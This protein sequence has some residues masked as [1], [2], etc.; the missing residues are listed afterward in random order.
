VDLPSRLARKSSKLSQKTTRMR[1]TITAAVTPTVGAR[2]AAAIPLSIG[3]RS[4]SNNPWSWPLITIP[5][6]TWMK[7]MMK[8]QIRAPACTR[9][10]SRTSE[11]VSTKTILHIRAL[12]IRAKAGVVGPLA[13]LVGAAF[14]REPVR[15]NERTGELIHSWTM[16]VRSLTK[17][18]ISLK[19]RASALQ[20][21]RV[22]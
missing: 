18:M 13:A 19:T 20:V 4:R 22:K 17:T 16:S 6:P 7:M 8:N 12:L 10:R 14:P 5:W 11:Q 9:C 3:V 1:T 15:G 2:A 21:Y